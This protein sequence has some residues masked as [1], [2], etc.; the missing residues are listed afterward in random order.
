MIRPRSYSIASADGSA[1]CSSS[2]QSCSLPRSVRGELHSSLQDIRYST[3]GGGGEGTGSGGGGGGGG[4]Y[5]YMSRTYPSGNGSSVSDR[6]RA[7]R[8]L[9]PKMS[10]SFERN[11]FRPID[12]QDGEITSVKCLLSQHQ[13]YYKLCTAVMLSWFASSVVKPQV[14]FCHFKARHT[15]RHTFKILHGNSFLKYEILFQIVNS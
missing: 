15:D 4:G 14:F 2:T 8:H 10:E 9:T 7:S 11:F 1:S 12:R 13:F 3:A 6:S 5:P